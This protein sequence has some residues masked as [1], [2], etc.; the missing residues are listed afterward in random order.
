[1]ETR[2][3]EE[4]WQRVSVKYCPRCIL[5]HTT[6]DLMQNVICESE[7]DIIQHLTSLYDFDFRDSASKLEK[8]FVCSACL[9]LLQDS[10]LRACVHKVARALED[11]CYVFPSFQL[12]YTLPVQLMLLDALAANDFKQLSK[13]LDDEPRDVKQIMKVCCVTLQLRSA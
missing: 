3:E 1:M 11:D 6:S 10:F 12:L 5:R 7:N 13:D 2:S 8:D 9:G 4:G